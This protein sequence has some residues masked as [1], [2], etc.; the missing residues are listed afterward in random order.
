MLV[1]PALERLRVELTGYCYRMLGSP[2]EAEDAVQEAFTRAWR[3]RQ[4]YDSGRASVR[5]WVYAIATTI[6]FI[7]RMAGAPVRL[8]GYS[9]GATVALAAAVR[10]PDLVE[11]LVLI[12]CAF[13]PA[14]MIVKPTADGTPPEPLVAAYAEV[15]PDGR[16]HFATV[17]AKVA[18][19]ASQPGMPATDLAAITCPVLVMA[20]DD[21]L[22]TLEHTLTLYRALPAA[23]LAVVP[24]TSHLLLHERP[25]LCTSLVTAFMTTDPAPT[26]MP[27]ARHH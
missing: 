24:R 11:R 16:D 8:A 15:S 21:D 22:V 10:R 3:D 6:A 27:L 14:G 23:Q 12:S 20:A 7:E 13:D 1:G 25:G 19:A 17:L 26:L 9:A 5:T 2:F 18:H 4:R